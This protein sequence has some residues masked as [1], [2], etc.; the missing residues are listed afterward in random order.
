MPLR[1][2]PPSRAELWW[3][4]AAILLLIVTGLLIVLTSGCAPRHPGAPTAPTGPSGWLDALMPPTSTA[5]SEGVE[6]SLWPFTSLGFL[7]LAG[8]LVW[9]LVSGKRLLLGIGFGLALT[10]AAVMIAADALAPALKAFVIPVSIAAGVLGIIWLIL[11]AGRWLGWW[12]WKRKSDDRALNL[13]GR[14]HEL[15]PDQA[16]RV[17]AAAKQ[18]QWVGRKDFD[19]DH[20]EIP[21]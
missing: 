19:P 16:A 10:P 9:F 4:V 5:V 12:E 17:K 20:P 8:G 7:C 11:A 15:P 18:L 3:S 14:A 21:S 13:L 1:P 2:P 6:R